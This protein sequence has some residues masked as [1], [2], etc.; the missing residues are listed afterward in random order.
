MQCLPLLCKAN[1]LVSDQYSKRHFLSVANLILAVLKRIGTVNGTLDPDSAL[2][3]EQLAQLGALVQTLDKEVPRIPATVP[4]TVQPAA[5]ASVLDPSA[6]ALVLR[7]ATTWPYKDRLPSLDLLRCMAASPS[8][9]E[10]TDHEGRNIL[11]VL[12]AIV[13][14]FPADGKTGLPEDAKAAE[15]NSMMVLRLIANLF[16]TAPGQQLVVKNAENVLDFFSGVLDF[17]ERKNRNLM[18]ALAS[19]ASNMISFAQRERETTGKL[20][21]SKDTLVRLAKI[22][23]VPILDLADGEVVYRSLVALGNLACIPGGE[24]VHSLQ[25]AGAESWVSAAVEKI[26]EERVGSVGEVILGLLRTD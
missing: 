16:I 1:L 24:Y 15:N 2:T 26:K 7:L 6:I 23:A 11:D 9:A 21:M 22:L 4:A 14:A 8:V 12:L 25:K 10:F 17:S 13:L 19:A 20:S 18:I 3:A 5:R